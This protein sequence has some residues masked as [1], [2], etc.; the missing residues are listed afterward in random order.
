M[1]LAPDDFLDDI[2]SDEDGPPLTVRPWLGPMVLGI[3]LSVALMLYIVGW[4]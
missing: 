1:V 2:E 3:G 4:V